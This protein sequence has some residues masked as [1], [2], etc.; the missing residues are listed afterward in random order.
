MPVQGELQVKPAW[1]QGLAAGP[2]GGPPCGSFS[3]LCP[4]EC[5]SRAWALVGSYSEALVFAFSWC[6]EK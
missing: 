2:E 5:P 6:V 3:L 1:A 4:A